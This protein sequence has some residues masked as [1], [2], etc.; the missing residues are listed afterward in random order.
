[1]IVLRK[2]SFSPVARRRSIDSFVNELFNSDDF[3]KANFRTTPS[4]TYGTNV[5]EQDGNLVYETE[6]PGLQK[7]NVAIRL[8]DGVLFI[9]GEIQRDETIKNEE[10]I[11][12][13]RRYG[14]FERHFTLPE[15]VEVESP[16]NI[17]A[18]LENGIL[19]V[20]L[21][22][23]QSLQPEVYEIKVD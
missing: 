2:N 7:D 18:K 15:G 13:G 14:K 16:E 19:T 10:F 8:E 6:M 12:A 4:V 11:S 5:Y 21:P 20:R 3:F 17:N 9:N 23:K 22:L 1:M